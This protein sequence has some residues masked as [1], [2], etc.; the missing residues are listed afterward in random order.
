MSR[1]ELQGDDASRMACEAQ[2][3]RPRAVATEDF[4]RPI[5]CVT[6]ALSALTGSVAS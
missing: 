1:T 2:Q 3:A 4:G 6:T 5:V